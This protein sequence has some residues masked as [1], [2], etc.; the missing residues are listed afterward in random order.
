MLPVSAGGAKPYRPSTSPYT[1]P[2]QKSRET[3]LTPAPGNH[4]SIGKSDLQRIC[5]LMKALFCRKYFV[6]FKKR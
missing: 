5:V 2:P 4:D 3:A 6:Y 1:L